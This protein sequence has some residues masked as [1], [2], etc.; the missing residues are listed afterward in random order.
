MPK[1][2]ITIDDLAVMVQKGF[3]ETGK[4]IDMLRSDIGGLKSD[5]TDVKS[6]LDRIEKIFLV[7]H[8][9]RIERLEFEVKNLKDLF[10][11]K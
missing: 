9:H 8:K 5:M 7:D 11:L 10:A 6:R 2:Q 1:K 4:K 3:L